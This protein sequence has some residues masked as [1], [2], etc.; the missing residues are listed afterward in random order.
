M[1]FVGDTMESTAPGPNDRTDVHLA[2]L[3]GTS[4]A[5][6]AL[7][8]VY[9]ATNV[10]PNTWSQAPGQEYPET[11]ILWREH[12]HLPGLAAAAA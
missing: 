10:T 7:G 9:R 3:P 2:V 6:V 1:A 8:H 11:R 4:R 5:G 12:L